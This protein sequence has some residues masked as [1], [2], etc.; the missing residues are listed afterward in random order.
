MGR[1]AEHV[2]THDAQ[3][4]DR[5]CAQADEARQHSE[6]IRQLVIEREPL[7]AASK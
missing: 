2:R 3:D 6:M 7:S 4:A 1:M 5:L